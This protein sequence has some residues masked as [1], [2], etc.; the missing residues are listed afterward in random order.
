[1]LAVKAV[2]FDNGLAGKAMEALVVAIAHCGTGGD[3]LPERKESN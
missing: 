3:G 1:V 2:F